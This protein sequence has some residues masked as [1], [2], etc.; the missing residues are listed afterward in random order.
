MDVSHDE[1]TLPAPYNRLA[2][3]RAALRA[4]WTGRRLLSPLPPSRLVLRRTS[5]PAEKP[6]SPYPSRSVSGVHLESSPSSATYHCPTRKGGLEHLA[7]LTP[8]FACLVSALCFT[9][10]PT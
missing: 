2:R 8:A 4:A 10:L 1:G 3:T 7:P 5:L 9:G 6:P